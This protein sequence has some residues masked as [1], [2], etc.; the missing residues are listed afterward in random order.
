MTLTFEYKPCTRSTKGDKFNHPSPPPHN[1]SL[2]LKQLS[3]LS[4]SPLFSRPFWQAFVTVLFYVYD[5]WRH[6]FFWTRI[7]VQDFAESNEMF[8]T[9]PQTSTK[10]KNDFRSKLRF[11][12]RIFDPCD[13]I[14][15]CLGL[16]TNMKICF[17][18]NRCQYWGFEYVIICVVLN[19]EMHR[20]KIICYIPWFPFKQMSWK[21]S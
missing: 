19:R 7:I 10:R 8:V 4:V 2:L 13:E 1:F 18:H 9:T 20:I 14:V 3:L 11:F 6:K 12:V 21:D 17:R 16:S 5:R 15:K